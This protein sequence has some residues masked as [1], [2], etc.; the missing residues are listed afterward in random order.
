[1]ADELRL[2]LEMENPA[3]Q[4]NELFG[5]KLAVLEMMLHDIFDDPT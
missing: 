5:E 2:D 1:V 4:W 3:D